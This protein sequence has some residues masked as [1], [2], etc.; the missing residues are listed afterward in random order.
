MEKDSLRAVLFF[1][2]RFAI[3][4]AARRCGG[5]MRPSRSIARQAS[6]TRRGTPAPSCRISMAMVAWLPATD[7]Q[8]R[9]HA[10]RAPV[11]APAS[12]SRDRGYGSS[13]GRHFEIAFVVAAGRQRA[14]LTG[15]DAISPASSRGSWM[16]D[17]PRLAIG[18][19][20]DDAH[21]AAQ[22]HIAVLVHRA[23]PAPPPRG[24]PH[25]PCRIRRSPA[26]CPRMRQPDRAG[27]RV[28]PCPS[29]SGR[30][31][32]PVRRRSGTRAVAKFQARRS[33]P[34]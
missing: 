13:A 12:R 20:A 25:T 19:R 2:A 6:P 10:D 16:R 29:R 5:G 23:R 24:R 33:T 18:L 7:R 32:A 17:Q 14:R 15:I 4:P 22:V 1:G 34:T 28:R 31:G 30:A 11:V 9:Q 3:G 8:R 26:P 27:A 21:V